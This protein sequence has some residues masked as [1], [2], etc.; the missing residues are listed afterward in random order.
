MIIKTWQMMKRGI[1]MISYKPLW[2]LLIE[3]DLNKLDLCTLVGISP[4]TVAKMSKN[5]YTSLEILDRICIVLGCPIEDVI[6]VEKT[7]V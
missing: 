3:K 4:T 2:K 1:V 5:K 7:A 6:K